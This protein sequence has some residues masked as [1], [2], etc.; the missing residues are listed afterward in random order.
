MSLNPL[1][2]PSATINLVTNTSVDH[3]YRL[4][5]TDRT[6]LNVPQDPCEEDPDYSFMVNFTLTLTYP[7]QCI[8][9]A[10]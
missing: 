3:Y 6:E 2:L 10:V 8:V 1:P 4:T 9:R 7:R 5:C